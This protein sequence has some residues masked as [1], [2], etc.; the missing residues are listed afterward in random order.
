M[1]HAICVRFLAYLC[2]PLIGFEVLIKKL[3]GAQCSNPKS[4]VCMTTTVPSLASLFSCS[5]L[6][7]SLA[8]RAPF[9]LAYHN[10]CLSTVIR[11]PRI[12]SWLWLLLLST[13]WQTAN[14]TASSSLSNTTSLS[15]SPFTPGAAWGTQTT[16]CQS[17]ASSSTASWSC[18]CMHN[19]RRNNKTTI[20]TK[21]QQQK[22]LQKQEKHGHTSTAWRAYLDWFVLGRLGL[23]LLCFH[24]YTCTSIAACTPAA[25]PGRNACGQLSCRVTNGFLNP[26]TWLLF[27]VWHAKAK[28]R[29]T[30]STHFCSILFSAHYASA[31]YG[32][33]SSSGT[34]WA[35]L[36]TSFT[37]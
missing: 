16:N 9:W 35:A 14:R 28:A 13:L 29:L 12:E 17:K 33:P 5:S 18:C 34:N 25:Q 27:I 3:C 26:S 32:S 1:S 30:Q 6:P 37:C 8:K 22:E 24:L 4:R 19:M 23:A 31:P 7:S 2:V 20:I 36:K 15:L 11:M 10:L 21:Q